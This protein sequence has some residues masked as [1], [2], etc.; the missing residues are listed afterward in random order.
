M[1]NATDGDAFAERF[2]AYCEQYLGISRSLGDAMTRAAGAGD[3]GRQAR[4]FAD[5]LAALQQQ[6]AGSWMA[7]PFGAPL[8]ATTPFAAGPAFGAGPMF[9]AGNPFAAATNPWAA[10]AP[11]A[12]L[13]GFA[14][15]AMAP[16][17]GPTR[18]LQ[19]IW[20]RAARLADELQQAQT[21]L[22]GLWN[23]VVTTAL[24]QLGARATSLLSG[25]AS[26][27][28]LQALYDQW[29]DTAESVYAQAARA[30]AFAAAQ[31]DFGNASS[32][33]RSAQRELI[34]LGAREFDLPTRA[35][36]NTVHQQLRDLKRS[37]REL[38]EGLARH[39]AGA[40]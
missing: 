24:Q 10:M 13:A 4:A 36:L 22:A 32:R 6:V 17:L 8:A 2:R 3:P 26:P 21:R 29:I 40:P 18:E 28:S 35:E 15:G 30:P 27:D 1:S 12:G 7:T 16:P 5:G 38:E 37:L 33:L 9:G 25:S 14:P 31:A 39:G 20:Q 19:E 34:E 23:E 11:A